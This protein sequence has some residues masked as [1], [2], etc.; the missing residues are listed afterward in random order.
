MSQHQVGKGPKKPKNIGCHG[1][2]YLICPLCA[3]NVFGNTG[4]IMC[5]VHA[6]KKRNDGR[7][8]WSEQAFKVWKCLLSD[9]RKVWDFLSTSTF[10]AIW[11]S[12]R[13]YQQAGM[14]QTS[15]I[16]G[17]DTEKTYQEASSLVTQISNG[18]SVNV[19]ENKAAMNCL[20]K[21][22]AEGYEGASSHW[23][24]NHATIVLGYF[25]YLAAVFNTD[26]NNTQEFT[27]GMKYCV[28]YNIHSSKAASD[29]RLQY[30][31]LLSGITRQQD[32]NSQRV[33][34]V[35]VNGDTL[36]ETEIQL[37]DYGILCRCMPTFVCKFHYGCKLSK[38]CGTTIYL[39][40]FHR[41]Q[42]LWK[43][44]KQFYE[45]ACTGKI[46][47]PESQMQAIARRLADSGRDPSDDLASK[48]LEENVQNVRKRLRSETGQVNGEDTT[49]S[50]GGSANFL[51][52]HGVYGGPSADS[53][54][55]HQ[56]QSPPSSPL[57]LHDDYMSM[58]SADSPWGQ[59]QP[60]NSTGSSIMDKATPALDCTALDCT[61]GYGLD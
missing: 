56:S 33:A 50:V 48:S 26:L 12:L 35:Y 3:I 9:R 23:V 32:I 61:R 13:C 37:K 59:F 8:M 27:P 11:S 55:G 58:H 46:C 20:R 14:L 6:K 52:N 47:I 1:G 15:S 2:S 49:M 7:Y 60:D 54:I 10:F 38:L 43:V 41:L 40:V 51:G 4:S 30:I 29:K 18:A 17:D 53:S 24:T 28:H 45:S 16:D 42:D 57:P 36:F 39:P 5:T 34:V 21:L 19:Y 25:A 44:N 22:Q 31:S